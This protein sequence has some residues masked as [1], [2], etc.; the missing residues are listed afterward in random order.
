MDQ[1][2]YATCKQRGH[3]SDGTS[4]TNSV[5]SAKIYYRCKYCGIRYYIEPSHIVEVE[6]GEAPLIPV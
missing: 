6:N 2:E 4:V 1:K 3:Q 5:T